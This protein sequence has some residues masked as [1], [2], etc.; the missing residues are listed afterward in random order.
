MKVRKIIL[1]YIKANPG[2][3]STDI[4]AAHG[5]LRQSI[6]GVLT[7]MC[8]ER[9]LSRK[10]E[11]R[12]FRYVAVDPLSFDTWEKRA[13]EL[14]AKVDEL[15]AW[16]QAAIA[17][18]PDLGVS[19]VLMQ[20]RKIVADLYRKQPNAIEGNINFAKRIENGEYDHLIEVESAVAALEA[21]QGA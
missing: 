13:R 19:P 7:S 18:Y 8:R 14:Q 9:V 5:L 2:C 1:D 11:G 12:T 21:A 17:K 15:Y 10:R 20:A 16:K 3:T 4:S 6:T